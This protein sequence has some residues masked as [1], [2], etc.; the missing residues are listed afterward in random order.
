MEHRSS[1]STR[2]LTLFCAVSFA[3]RHVSPFSSNS[4]ILVRLQVCRGLPLLRFPCGFHS[5]ALLAT[6]PSSSLACGQSNPTLVVLSP[7]L[8]AAALF[9]S[10]APHYRLFLATK[11]ARCSA[12][13]CWWTPAISASI[14]WSA[15]KFPNHTRAPF[16]HLTE[17]PGC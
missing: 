15:S 10:K 9:V 1:T 11:S 14:P 8:S 12:G 7:P 2:H 16:S 13:S 3:S 6:C 17:S 4:D 5:R